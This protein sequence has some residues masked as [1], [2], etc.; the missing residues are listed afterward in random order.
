M[1]IERH[2][3][4]RGWVAL[5]LRKPVLRVLRVDLQLNIHTITHFA[6][7]QRVR[8]WS[9]RRTGLR[10]WQFSDTQAILERSRN[11]HSKTSCRSM[12]QCRGCTKSSISSP[13]VCACVAC[14]GS[15]HEAVARDLGEDGGGGDAADARVALDHQLRRHAQLRVPATTYKDK[16]ISRQGG[17]RWVAR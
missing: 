14:S 17:E 10:S 3:V 2:L 4:G 13:C 11:Q 1:V 16:S 15:Y 12:I 5:V 6:R 7:G 9:P 8:M